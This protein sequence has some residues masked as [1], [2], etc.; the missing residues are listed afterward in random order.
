MPG[1]LSGDAP[2]HLGCCDTWLAERH[3]PAWK[4]MS[5]RHHRAGPLED[6]GALSPQETPELPAAEPQFSFMSS[7]LWVISLVSVGACVV[8]A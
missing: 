4:E 8:A 3:V 2:V 5:S 6:A 7:P 1:L